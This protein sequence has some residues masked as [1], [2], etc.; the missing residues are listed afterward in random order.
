MIA[1]AKER[2]L[3]LDV[4]Q[5]F[6]VEAGAGSGKTSILSQRHLAALLTVDKPEQVLSMTFTKD[7]A[8]EMRN[9]ISSSLTSALSNPRPESE[10]EKISY[11]LALKVIEKDKL[12]NWGLLSNLQRLSIMTIDSL[13]ASIAK[14]APL[15]S[16]IGGDL[17]ITD[18]S[19]P[20]YT[21]AAT[22]VLHVLNEEDH[23]LHAD[24]SNLI[25]HLNGN[26]QR[27]VD[28][29]A[30]MLGK[31]DQWL[32]HIVG[33]GKVIDKDEIIRVLSSISESVQNKALT[34]FSPMKGQ[35]DQLLDMAAANVPAGH[36]LSTGSQEE[37]YWE[38]V[39]ELF[40]TAKG[41]L[42]KK[43][44]KSQGF[45]A[46]KA[47][48][49]EKEFWADVAANLST[50]MIE[51]VVQVN[52]LPA[53]DFEEEQWEL[54]ESLFKIL[55]R[56]VGELKLIFAQENKVDFNE[57]SSRAL[58]AIRPEDQT[59]IA[60]KLFSI[61]QHILLDEGQDTNRTQ[62]AIVEALIT[63]WDA[64]MNNSLFI[65]GDPKQSI[66]RFREA[67]VGLFMKA[68]EDGLGH[69]KLTVLRLTS[70][71]RTS[72]NIV[73]WNNNTYS[74]SF[75]Q[76]ADLSLGA[77][78]YE[79]A[80]PV[81]EN[82]STNPVVVKPLMEKDAVKEAE[83]VLEAITEA[84]AEFPDGDIAILVRSRPHLVEVAKL[85]TT[86]KVSYQAVEIERLNQRQC[87][88][89]ALSLTKALMHHGDNISWLSLL[90][91]P[92]FALTLN[93][94][95]LLTGDLG[96]DLVIERI[97]SND[98][99]MSLSEGGQQALMELKRVM[100]WALL[101]QGQFSLRQ[102]V[103]TVWI[104]M[105]APAGYIAS[106]LK[107]IEN[108]F[109]LLQEY[110]NDISVDF[111]ALERKL[112][113]LFAVAEETTQASK[114]KLMTMHK[115]KGL[116][117]DT[118]ILPG[119]GNT[120]RPPTGSL[121]MWHELTTE[122]SGLA[123][124]MILSP[125]KGIKENEL[126]AY[127]MSIESDKASYE[128]GRLMYV[129]TTRPK[130]KLFLIGHINQKTFGEKAIVKK[131]ASSSL[132]SVIWESVQKAFLDC[133]IETEPQED[134]DAE[135]DDASQDIDAGFDYKKV[136]KVNIPTLPENIIS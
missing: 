46:G 38:K 1:D 16:G 65:V 61:Y 59:F 37:N 25:L 26:Q 49:G 122:T 58:Q 68:K 72:E 28:L 84:Q 107:D 126:Y 17:N 92:V 120:P 99:L 115:S 110:G 71:F 98:R 130:K 78:P 106:E 11:D 23:P 91:M 77:V 10:Y 96:E 134:D 108:F 34:V 97:Y 8:N 22:E 75:P 54:L 35:V 79:N 103:E 81:L 13:C 32:R 53:L 31:R 43:P 18:D 128:A 114:I 12:M 74:A 44:T 19:F 39:S 83:M 93:D 14:Q 136:I 40:L 121:V 132:L 124:D 101:N 69:I 66:Y 119:L 73:T 21:Q 95:T 64:S 90:R 100:D 36:L 55:L 20:F 85:L 123:G 112:E 127:L 104:R 131:P 87:V 62:Y 30:E 67:D 9:R 15:L 6:L 76:L 4:T 41:E 116:E 7:A 2:Q 89:D 52:S 135:K 63:E 60:S 82:K 80:S 111:Q 5:S 125:I 45:P 29:I 102:Y 88:N 113:N 48:A 105:N 33:Q 47:H 57:V 50:S 42:R 133:A 51:L 118:V 109:K 70:N 129:A 3:A 24:I 117:F 94:L 56:A 27:A 86:N